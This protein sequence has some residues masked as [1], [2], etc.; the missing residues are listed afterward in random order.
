M[1]GHGLTCFICLSN[2]GLFMCRPFGLQWAMPLMGKDSNP[3]HM[4]M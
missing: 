1:G 2:V 4:F 3:H